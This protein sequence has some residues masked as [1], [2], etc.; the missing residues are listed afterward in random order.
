LAYVALDF[1]VELQ[2][3]ATTADVNVS[4][5]LPDGDEIVI[6]RSAS[7][8]WNG[9]EFDGIDETLFDSGLERAHRCQK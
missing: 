1:E 2:K 9:F 3:V 6:G 4:D 8:A 5:T 7:T